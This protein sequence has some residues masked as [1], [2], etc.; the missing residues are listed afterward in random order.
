MNDF[1]ATLNVAAPKTLKG[2]DET[3]NISGFQIQIKCIPTIEALYETKFY[4]EM[5]IPFEESGLNQ[6]YLKVFIS[7][8]ETFASYIEKIRKEF[9]DERYINRPNDAWFEILV[10]GHPLAIVNFALDARIN[11]SDKVYLIAF[12]QFFSILGGDTPYSFSHGLSNNLDRCF[13]FAATLKSY[14][15]LGALLG[16][17][18][19]LLYAGSKSTDAMCFA[20][21]YRSGIAESSHEKHTVFFL[22]L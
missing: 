14:E 10:N 5:S 13:A 18:T 12:Y 17:E 16:A 19:L 21:G 22:D 3:F 4:K 15:K 20:M 2:L 7:E 11:S 6:N 9:K 8:Q 1:L